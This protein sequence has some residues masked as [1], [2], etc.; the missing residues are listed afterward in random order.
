[1]PGC[2]QKYRKRIERATCLKIASFCIIPTAHCIH[3]I[4]VVT[5]ERSVTDRIIDWCAL[6]TDSAPWAGESSR[7]LRR[8][9][10]QRIIGGDTAAASIL[11]CHVSRLMSAPLCHVLATLIGQ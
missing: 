5:G 9:L 1:M 2:V 7:D 8:S 3:S 4:P 11:W 10:S 6:P